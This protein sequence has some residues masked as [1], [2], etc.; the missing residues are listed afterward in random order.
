MATAAVPEAI[1]IRR[2]IISVL[3]QG[4][5]MKADKSKKDCATALGVSTSVYA[6]YEA[7]RRDISLPELE[8]LAHFLKM[9]VSDFFENQDRVVKE[10]TP[11][12][13][14]EVVQLRQRIIGA[15]LR[16]VR[17]DKSKSAK[18]LAEQLGISPRRI[19]QYEYGQLPIPISQ[20]QEIADILQMPM[21]YFIDEGHGTIGEEAAMRNQ[22]RQFSEL[23]DDIRRFVANQSNLSYLRVAQR[24]ANM[25]TEQLRDIAAAILDITY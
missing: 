16:K 20:L 23:P 18:E 8:V 22:F 13:R 7:G 19:T 9:P 24:L 1:A 6:A 12:S 5:R 11:V 17:L 2:K 10:E 3:L 15:L 25:T 21:R 14:A 4:A